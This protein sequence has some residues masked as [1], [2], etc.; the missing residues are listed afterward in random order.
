MRLTCCAKLG[1]LSAHMSTTLTIGSE[2]W[3]NDVLLRRA[4]SWLT[5]IGKMSTR[6][7][8]QVNEACRVAYAAIAKAEGA[9]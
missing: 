7:R 1:R 2:I 3:G 9:Q 8:A 4:F 6:E 5:R